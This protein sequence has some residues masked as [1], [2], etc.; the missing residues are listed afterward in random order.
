MTLWYRVSRR[1]SLGVLFVFGALVAQTGEAE[2]KPTCGPGYEKSGL[3]CYPKCTAGYKG[4]GPVC[5]KRCP[6]GWTDIGVSCTKPKA[7]GRGVGFPWKFGDKAFSLKGAK[8]RCEQKHGVGKCEKNGLIYYPKCKAG[9]HNVGCCICSPDCPSGFKD[10]GAFCGKDAKG[11]GVGQPM[12]N[13][14]RDGFYAYIKSHIG[15]YANHFGTKPLTAS[16]KTYLLKFF[17][18]RIVDKVLVVEPLVPGTGFFNHKASA[19]TYGHIVAVKKGKRTNRLLKHELVH[20]CQYDRDGIKGFSHRY[21]DEWIDSGY[22][23]MGIP[24]EKQAYAYVNK[25]DH[26]QNYIPTCKDPTPPVASTEGTKSPG[27]FAVAVGALKAAKLKPTRRFLSQYYSRKNRDYVSHTAMNR[28][29]L[30]LIAAGTYRRV[31]LQASILRKPGSNTIPLK[32]LWH[33]GRKE[34][35]TVARPKMIMSLKKKGYMEIGTAGHLLKK[36]GPGTVPVNLYSTRKDH[37]LVVTNRDAKRAKRGGY[38]ARGVEG[39]AYRVLLR[40]VANKAKPIPVRRVKPVKKA[41]TP[42]RRPANKRM[43]FNKAP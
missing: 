42:S 43:R 25:A 38:R 31:G 13:T 30:G 26:I 9:F 27:R 10:H 21:A 14:A 4:V 16:E 37:M 23:Y 29:P 40:A 33:A 6:S 34:T 32:V 39:Y 17:P 24:M 1:L 2:A 8:K 3:L 7:Y 11:R 36:A 22:S 20:V 19:T 18:K 5:W 35:A 41:K 15:Y 12:R 28:G